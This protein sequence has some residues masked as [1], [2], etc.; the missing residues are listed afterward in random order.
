M[1]M[2]KIIRILAALM[3]VVITTVFF[4]NLYI[5]SFSKKK[6]YRY[7]ADIPANTYGLI[8]GTNKYLPKGG[9]N[10]YYSERIESTILLYQAGKIEKI[11][12]SGNGRDQYYNEPVTIKKELIKAGIPDSL[13]QTDAAGFRT[14]N[15]VVNLKREINP[16]RMTI[17]SQKF[18]NQRAVFIARRYGIDAIAYNVPEKFTSRDYPTRAREVLAKTRAVFELVF[19]KQI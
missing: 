4:C 18:H 11:I 7:I 16:D 13:I 19:K 1:L 15:S 6:L 14:H 2:R 9:I 5:N 8:L 17:I 3:L 10:K 12:V